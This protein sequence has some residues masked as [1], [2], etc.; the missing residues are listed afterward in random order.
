MS[1]SPVAVG[2]NPAA[3][4]F[5][6][7]GGL[8]I[9]VLVGV[10]LWVYL[11][12]P[13]GGPFNA[14][15]RLV[16]DRGQLV[17]QS[18]FKR[19]PALVYFGYTHCP[20]VCPTTL[21]EVADWLKTLG[22]E[23]QPLHAYFFT[24]DPKRDTQDVMHAYVSSFGDRITGVTGDEAEMEKVSKGWMIHA[25]RMP[26]DDPNYHMSHTTSLLLI[27]GEGKLKG[28]VPY[29]MAKDEAIERIRESLL[30]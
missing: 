25:A 28:L 23:G 5:A 4:L 20:E 2:N 10:M 13:R 26:G 14:E 3:K 11:D 27:S 7:L 1:D 17:D 15:F 19:G 18:V 21:F 8:F 6:A 24:I 30:R 12:S 29:G 22:E 16:D 9:A